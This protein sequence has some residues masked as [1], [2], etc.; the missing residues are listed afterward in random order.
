MPEMA[1]D[2]ASEL[3]VNIAHP[4]RVSAGAPQ[5]PV[6]A[7]FGGVSAYQGLLLTTT[8]SMYAPTD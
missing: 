3:P 5:R 8:L 6:R 7:V 4:K 1:T 2:W